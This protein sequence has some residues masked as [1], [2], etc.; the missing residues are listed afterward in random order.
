MFHPDTPDPDAAGTAAPSR[1]LSF[2]EVAAAYAEHRPGYAAEAVA[3]AV[4]P[5]G[6]VGAPHLLDLGAG[7]GKLTERLVGHP[8]AQVTAVEPD[9]AMLAELRARLPAVDARPGTAESVPLPDVSVDAVLVG[10]AWH[11]FDAGRALDEIVRVLR[12]GGVLAVV[13][14][15]EDP[16]QRLMNDFLDVDELY[17][18]DGGHTHAAHRPA[19]PALDGPAERRFPH[20][21]P[22]TVDATVARMRTYSWM[23]AA[24]PDERAAFE[25][26]L[27][28]YL[29]T[30]VGT[31]P[32]GFTL[33]LLTTV[34]R[35]VRHGRPPR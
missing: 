10:Q 8:G 31:A 6:G 25:Q 22:T 32:D 34:L 17:A 2:G 3:W 29:G 35:S 4:E 9:P 14:N 11:W 12:P 24:A 23:L 5:L 7:T 15:D 33:P 26:R 20:P 1:A 30:R 13:R 16:E 18:R 19:H 28:A 27:R 21:H